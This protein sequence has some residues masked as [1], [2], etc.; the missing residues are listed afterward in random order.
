MIASTHNRSITPTGFNV[1]GQRMS[2]FTKQVLSQLDGNWD[3]IAHRPLT[4]QAIDTLEARTNLRLPECL[5]DY[6]AQVGL[7]QDLTQGGS[8]RII[9]FDSVSEWVA[10]CQ[11][12]RDGLYDTVDVRLFPFARSPQGDLFALYPQGEHDAQIYKLDQNTLMLI[13]TNF[14]FCGWLDMIVR[15]AL[16]DVKRRTPNEQK[17][18]SV[19]FTFRST[20]LDEI[21]AIMQEVGDVSL[22]NEPW[23]MPSESAIDVHK[24]VIDLDFEGHLL[25][26]KQLHH[27][28]WVAPWHFIDM[29]EPLTTP[30]PQSLIQQLDDRFSARLS[31]YGLISHGAVATPTKPA[32]A[33]AYTLS[34]NGKVR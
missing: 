33:N 2:S 21:I 1:L 25:H 17:S 15:S 8:N 12:V 20:S 32:I 7:V 22:L 29:S 13:P 30:S 9:P 28:A 18:W 19:Q 4:M 24:T 3:V 6:L 27:G 10:A 23:D 26:I 34:A 11:D 16:A 31:G 14:T 5:R